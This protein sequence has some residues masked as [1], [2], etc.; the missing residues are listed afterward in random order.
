M[1]FMGVPLHVI[2]FDSDLIKG[3]VAVGVGPQFPIEGVSFIVGNNLA[4]GKVLVNAEV[5][6]V[7]LSENPHELEQKYP[8]VFSVCAVT[9]AIRTKAGFA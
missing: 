6:V 2:H 7:P 8:E 5:I 3:R 1:E 9:R 4:R